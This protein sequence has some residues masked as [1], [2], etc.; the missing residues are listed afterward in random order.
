MPRQYRD[1]RR[2]CSTSY[3]S[4]LFEGCTLTISVRRASTEL[5]MELY[6]VFMERYVCDSRVGF[7]VIFNEAADA[8]YGYR[9]GNK[10]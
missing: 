3:L 6:K 1:D 7:W 4:R 9:P 8:N 10:P 5:M 2:G